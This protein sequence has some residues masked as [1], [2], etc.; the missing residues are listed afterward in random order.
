MT[1]SIEDL[2]IWSRSAT[3][4]KLGEDFLV[5]FVDAHHA[6]II[7]GPLQGKKPRPA[8]YGRIMAEILW[9]GRAQARKMLADHGRFEAG[10]EQWVQIR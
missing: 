3:D 4:F 1:D 7:V 6:A 5:G 8:E 9:P 2:A 10:Q